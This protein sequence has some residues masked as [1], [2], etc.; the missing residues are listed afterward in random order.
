MI[1]RLPLPG[2]GSRFFL[3]FAAVMAAAVG[4]AA[5]KSPAAGIGI[6]GLVC[7]AAVAV[8]MTRLRLVELTLAALPWLVVFDALMPS[9][10][11][12]FVAT[13]AVASMLW[14]S[15]PLRYKRMMGPI[16]AVLFIATMC[17]NVVFATDS[18]QLIQFAKF[19]IFPTAALAVLSDG[20]QERLRGAHKVVMGSCLAAMVVHLG[21]IAA[22]LGQTGTKYNIGEKLGY[23][24]GIV[25]EMTL[26]F[27][28]IAA[29]GLV[30]SKRLSLQITFFALGAIPALLTGVRSALLALIVVLFIFIVRLGLSKK[31]LITV[32]VLF[33][34]AF[35][36]GGVQIVQNRFEQSSKQETSIASAGS[37]RGAIWKTAF[38]PWWNSGPKEWLFGT[39]LRSIEKRELEELGAALVGHSDVIQ[40]GIEFGL[41]LFIFWLLVW[42]ALLRA[43]L[44]NIVLVP[45]IVYAL[46]NGSIEYVAPVTLGL[47]FSAS[48]RAVTAEEETA[49]E[50]RRDLVTA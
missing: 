45:L 4:A 16:A 38:V 21:V 44:E 12:T 19:L 14:L 31:A 10:L 24:R 22:G 33:A 28:V 42:L 46:V 47:A 39:G 6:V 3:V 13:A 27:V 43:P 30:S 11:K 20:G 1:A 15:V 9:L 35:V 23:G 2:I 26:T 49:D 34:A 41:V 36:S 5:A 17:A 32:V 48:C 25:H 50:A 37:G 8:D 40:V 18:S 7:A 29:A